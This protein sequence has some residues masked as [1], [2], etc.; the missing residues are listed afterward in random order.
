MSEGAQAHPRSRSTV[1]ISRRRKLRKT[2]VL[3]EQIVLPLETTARCCRYVFAIQSALPRRCPGLDDREDRAAALL[4]SAFAEIA[5]M[6]DPQRHLFRLS[7]L[8]PLAWPDTNLIHPQFDSGQGHGG[9]G[10]PSGPWWLY[11]RKRTPD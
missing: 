2:S 11:A 9:S 10:G 5:H 7:Y 8:I 6:G 1:P 4:L 3:D